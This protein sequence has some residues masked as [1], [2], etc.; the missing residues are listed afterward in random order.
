MHKSV[1]RL[2]LCMPKLCIEKMCSSCVSIIMLHLPF[3]NFEKEIGCNL[4]TNTGGHTALGTS[5]IISGKN[6]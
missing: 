2:N 1:I 6:S 3:Y 5:M 4:L